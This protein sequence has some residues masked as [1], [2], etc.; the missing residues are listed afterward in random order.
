MQH[1]SGIRQDI[2]DKILIRRGKLYAFDELLPASTALIVIDLGMGTGRDDGD[3]LNR[4]ARNAN[5][6]ALELRQYGGIVAWVT[7]PIK[8]ATD[9]FR[10]VFGKDLTARYEADGRS[11]K[12]KK[13]WDELNVKSGDIHATK[14]THSAFSPLGSELHTRLQAKGIDTLLI[15]G[16][17]TNVC[18]EA[19]ARD[20]AELGYKV[21]MIS[22]AL[23]GWSEA[24]D[25]ATFATFARCYGDVRP[26]GDAIRLIE[27]SAAIK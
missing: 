19:T 23:I 25:Q 18:C 5:S 2:I 21:T 3:R 10:A 15:V 13:L 26:T 8:T 4:V 24:Q 12:S 27:R 20:G 7:T 6:L 11:G 22:D 1:P 16:A 14:Q 17:V 9:N